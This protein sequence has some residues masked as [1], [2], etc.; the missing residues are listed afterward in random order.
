MWNR[1]NRGLPPEMK[2]KSQSLKRGETTF[3]RK[4]EILLQSWRDTHV[5]NM[6]S[7]IHDSTMVDVP[8]RNE[9]VKKNLFCIFHYNMFMKVVGRADQYLS[10][11]SLLRK[12]V[13][14]PKKVAFWLIYCALF[15]SFRIYQKLNPTSKMRYKEFLLQVAK[16]WATDK[17]ET[18]TDAARPGTSTQ[19]PRVPQEDPPGRLSGDMWKHVLEKI[20]GSEGVKENILLGGAMFV[21]PTN[22]VKLGT[23]AS[24]A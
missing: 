13:K 17:M 10:Y 1:V 5:V 19:T 15:N 11:Y 23:S 2:N 8:R 6:I 22:E 24:S 3:R 4:G 16:D 14:W 18:D 20:V 21:L 9:E 12:T 7:T